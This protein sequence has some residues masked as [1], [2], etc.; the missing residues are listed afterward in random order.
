MGGQESKLKEQFLYAIVANK[1]GDVA[2]FLKV[3]P[4]LAI[5]YL[6]SIGIS[7]L[8]KYTPGGGND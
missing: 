3:Q 5:I 7:R 4:L 2:N 1:E 6:T 8:H